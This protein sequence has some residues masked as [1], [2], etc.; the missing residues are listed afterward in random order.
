MSAG[1]GQSL[2]SVL[3]PTAFGNAAPNTELGRAYL[4]LQAAHP[5]AHATFENAGKLGKSGSAATVEPAIAEKAR[6][7]CVRRHGCPAHER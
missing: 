4:E 7:I 5:G 6:A 1:L 3:R 2:T